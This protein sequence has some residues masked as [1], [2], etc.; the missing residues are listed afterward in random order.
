MT[1][2]SRK[3]L[4]LV[5][6]MVAV[7]PALWL[8]FAL[9]NYR[10]NWTAS[11]PIGIWQ[12]KEL[13]RAYKIGD[14]V[15]ICPPSARPELIEARKRG[16]LRPGSCLGNLAPLIK[17]IVAREGQLIEVKENIWISGQRL[18]HSELLTF[19]DQGR[20]LPMSPSGP[21]PPRHIFVHSNHRA[22][23]DSRYFGS[24]PVANI[25][26]HAEPVWPFSVAADD[27]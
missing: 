10:I 22:S 3:R 5:F 25:L 11:Y 19:D 16:Y 18:A 20:P 15:F 7:L 12:I 17:R 23:Y 26:G 21:V 6:A 14:L 4:G 9:G 2:I 8:I 27:D 1:G 24:L 13:D